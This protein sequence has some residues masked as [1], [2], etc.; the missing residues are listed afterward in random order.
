MTVKVNC[1]DSRQLDWNQVFSHF[2]EFQISR[3]IEKKEGRLNLLNCE[4]GIEAHF[5]KDS[6]LYKVP[7]HWNEPK[8]LQRFKKGL[9]KKELF[10][11]ALHL[12]TADSPVTVF[13]MTGGF[14]TDSLM[15]AR[16]EFEVVI[17]EESAFLFDLLAWNLRSGFL[18]T[19]LN[20]Y[21]KNIKNVHWGD[22]TLLVQ[23]QVESSGVPQ[24]IYLD[25]MFPDKRKKSL[26]PKE[27]QLLQLFLNHSDLEDKA[28]HLLDI[29]LDIGSKKVVLKRPLKSPTLSP[30]PTHQFEGKTIRYDIYS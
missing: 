10:S 26:A 22:S 6:Q 11:K 29:G 23:Q 1:I 18:D 4:K 21:L 16:M 28:Q 3:E 13:D 20:V 14:A 7:L 17:F 30:K 5:Y 24:V 19:E 8:F 15:M 9:S 2:K 12:K 27:M 25:P